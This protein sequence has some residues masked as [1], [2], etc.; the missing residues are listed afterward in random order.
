MDKGGNTIKTSKE[1]KLNSKV[2]S[3]WGA[4]ISIKTLCLLNTS[5]LGT[6]IQEASL[7]LIQ[8]TLVGRVVG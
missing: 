2:N 8:R 6:E 7:G 1:I 3:I 5:H 4:M